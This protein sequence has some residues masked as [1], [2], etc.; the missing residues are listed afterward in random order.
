[1]VNVCHHP[2]FG[3]RKEDAGTRQS[4]L[5]VVVTMTGMTMVGHLT[6]VVPGVMPFSDAA[7]PRWIHCRSTGAQDT[8]AGVPLQAAI[9]VLLMDDGWTPAH[10]AAAGVRRLHEGGHGL[11]GVCGKMR[12][13]II[14]RCPQH[15]KR[16]ARQ[17]VS[18]S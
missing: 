2:S 1:M 13:A 16:N 5:R 6:V 8:T 11:P 14:G 18:L 10:H 7:T 9:T 4:R 17:G 12:Q 3:V 15:A